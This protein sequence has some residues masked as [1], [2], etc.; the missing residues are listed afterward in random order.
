MAN[1]CTHEVMCE[2]AGRQART[3]ARILLSEDHFAVC[4]T[5]F[6]MARELLRTMRAMRKKLDEAESSAPEGDSPAFLDWAKDTSAG[7]VSLGT[8]EVLFG[9]LTNAMANEMEL[10]DVRFGLMQ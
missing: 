10:G 2:S 6:E 7:Y 5:P 4:E 9:Q 8:V 1:E 3:A